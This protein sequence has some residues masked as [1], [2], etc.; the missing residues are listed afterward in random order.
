MNDQDI[1][2]L[3]KGLE[4]YLNEKM[5]ESASHTKNSLLSEES[6][7]V[8][9]I[10]NSHTIIES[11]LASIDE[12]FKTLNG[13]VAKQQDKLAQ[14][15]IINAQITITQQQIID[16]LKELKATD[17]ATLKKNDEENT[18]Y[19]NKASGSLDTFKWLFGF[20]GIGN[21]ALIIKMFLLK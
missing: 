13:S 14:H 18:K 7:L 9:E 8:G 2:N 4:P 17:L 5:K 15:D 11:R 6:N 10:K 16:S 1:K 19:R 20:L 12:R 21:I 3:I